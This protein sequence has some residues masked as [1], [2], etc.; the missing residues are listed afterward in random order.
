MD[1]AALFILFGF[2]AIMYWTVMF[3]FHR[4]K[5]DINNTKK[6]KWAILTSFIILATPIW[7]IKEFT[8]IDRLICF[9]VFLL[10]GVGNYFT[11]LRMRRIIH[12]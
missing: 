12:K 11:V 3:F 2:I 10:I 4:D 5:F 1:G 7:L 6:G 9:L 8:L